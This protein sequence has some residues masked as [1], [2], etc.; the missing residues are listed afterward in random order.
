MVLQRTSGAAMPTAVVACCI[1]DDA[2]WCAIR[3][4]S[5][6]TT[7]RAFFFQCINIY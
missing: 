4:F 6:I 1:W 3:C 5:F 2:E 7:Q